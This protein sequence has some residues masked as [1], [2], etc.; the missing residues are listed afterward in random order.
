[1]NT[2]IPGSVTPYSP[3]QIN[4]FDLFDSM[5]NSTGGLTLSQVCTITGLEGST[6]QNWVKRGWVPRPIEK[7]YQNQQLARI[8]I[9]NALKDSLQLEQIINLLGVLNGQV[10]DFSDD[11][12]N[13]FELYN[14]FCGVVKNINIT[15]SIDFD[16]LN[17]IIKITTEN[18]TGFFDNCQQILYNILKIMTNYYISGKIKQNTDLFY[19]EFI[20]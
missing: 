12:I 13:E 15:H 3:N 19:K 8:L 11:K 4:A 9:I 2:N 10:N 20:N 16:H 1:M 17:Q 7:K 6:I 5:I 18:F 14:Y